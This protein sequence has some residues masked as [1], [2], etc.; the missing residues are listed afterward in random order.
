MC[1]QFLGR[2]NRMAMSS[3]VEYQRSGSTKPLNFE[4]EELHILDYFGPIRTIVWKVVVPQTRVS[5]MLNPHP[6]YIE[7]N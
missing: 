3:R 1:Q 2:F 5:Q 6:S 4:A 7:L